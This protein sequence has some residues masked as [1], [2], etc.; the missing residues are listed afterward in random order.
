LLLLVVMWRQLS[1]IAHAGAVE[2]EPAPRTRTLDAA[3]EG[4]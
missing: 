3:A 1:H 4:A 2:P